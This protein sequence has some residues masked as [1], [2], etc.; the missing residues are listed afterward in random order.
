MP[1][2]ILFQQ[3]SITSPK[4]T[5]E[6]TKLTMKLKRGFK[7]ESEKNSVAI[8]GALGVNINER[9]CCFQLLEYL[10]VKYFSVDE[11]D[12]HFGSCADM[13]HT[14]SKGN[15][16]KEFSAILFRKDEGDFVIYNPFHSSQRIRSTITHEA[17][18]MLC[19]HP[20]IQGKYGSHFLF[21]DHPR[22]MEDEAN[23]LAGCI[24]IPSKGMEWAVR[25]KMGIPHI[26]KHF[27][28]SEQLARWRYNMLGMAKR[29]KYIHRRSRSY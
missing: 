14:C 23:W 27:D 9:I 25:N 10:G 18:H 5:E 15:G 22:E 29:S 17:S 26:A 16:Q 8:R 24:L 21:R 1:T 7:S 28:V 3:N 20:F 19:E 6:N 13:V 4:H 12:S 11:F 2:K